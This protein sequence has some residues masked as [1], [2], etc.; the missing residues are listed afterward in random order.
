[1][2]ASTNLHLS[3]STCLMTCMHRDAALGPAPMPLSTT[4]RAPPRWGNGP[5][6]ALYCYQAAHMAGL[7]WYVAGDVD[8]QHDARP[9]DGG[10]DPAHTPPGCKVLHGE[11]LPLAAEPP[12]PQ[13]GQPWEVL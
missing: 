10:Q 9:L 13:S 8:G 12:V 1:M 3:V 2:A 6:P 7:G 11:L 4:N 5:L